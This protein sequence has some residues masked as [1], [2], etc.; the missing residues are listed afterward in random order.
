MNQ[1]NL[2]DQT[3]YKTKTRR[4]REEKRKSFMRDYQTL[5]SKEGAVQIQVFETLAKWHGYNSMESARAT[6]FRWVK[7]E[8]ND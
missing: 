5:M 3:L 8:S 6:Y 7:T 1:S 4:D 2:N